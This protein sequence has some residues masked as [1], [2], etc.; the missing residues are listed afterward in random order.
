[1]I[2]LKCSPKY[3]GDR[4]SSGM[5]ACSIVG[6]IRYMWKI[7]RC[8]FLTAFS[9]LDSLCNLQFVFRYYTSPTGRKLRSLVEIDRY[10]ILVVSSIYILE[11]HSLSTEL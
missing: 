9:E 6:T 5:H 4:K 3:H 10:A 7:Q 8:I 11:C 1:M 2:F